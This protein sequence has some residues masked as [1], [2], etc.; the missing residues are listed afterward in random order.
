MGMPA[1]A[2]VGV[3]GGTGFADIEGLQDRREVHIATPFGPPS[4]AYTLGSL[5]G[6]PLAFLPRHGRGHHVQPTDVNAHAN[7]FG[8]KR[9][10]VE[11]LISVSA[12]GSLREEFA[13]QHIIVPDQL[14]DH[15]RHRVSTFFGNGI[16][17]HVSFAQPY[18]PALG[19]VLFES[20]QDVDV[21]L[22]KGGA[23]ICMEGPQF[24][25]KAESE[26]YRRW[27]M[28]VIG[29]T[30]VPEAK[31][32]REAEICY[33]TL[34]CV[35]DYDVWHDTAGEVTVEMVVENLHQNVDHAKEIVRR[36]ITALPAER[37]GCPCPT[38]LANAIITAP[39]S[40]PPAQRA[41][42]DLLVGKYL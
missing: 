24:S 21:A 39:E 8:F 34:A 16:V 26:V 37:E 12:C 13:P 11:F 10:G 32:A 15:T 28:D 30:A 14:Y 42:L 27:G 4:D 17:A 19:D 33:A 20:G 22:H 7:I 18:C 31:L 29:M 2:R 23:Y 9:L 41:T 35:T 1:A 25:T 40:V 5:Q 36:A 3:I 6:I 38:A